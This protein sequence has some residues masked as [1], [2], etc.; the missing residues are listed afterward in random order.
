MADK[1]NVRQT[2]ADLLAINYGALY[3]ALIRLEKES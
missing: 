2:G 1:A 3:P